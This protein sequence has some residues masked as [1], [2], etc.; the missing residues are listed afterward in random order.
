MTPENMEEVL[1]T[2]GGYEFDGLAVFILCVVLMGLVMSSITLWI[3]LRSKKTNYISRIYI[4]S[5]GSILLS[6]SGMIGM[7][8]F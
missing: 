4:G 3:A 5:L 2:I 7:A 6:L 8:F 1:F